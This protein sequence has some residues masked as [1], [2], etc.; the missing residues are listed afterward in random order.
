MWP[1]MNHIPTPHSLGSFNCYLVH[2]IGDLSQPLFDLLH[3]FTL[4]LKLNRTSKQNKIWNGRKNCAHEFLLCSCTHTKRKNK[5][6]KRHDSEH[7]LTRSFTLRYNS[8]SFNSATTSAAFIKHLMVKAYM[9]K[10]NLK[11]LL[12]HNAEFECFILFYFF[13]TKLLSQSLYFN[14]SFKKHSAR[15]GKVCWDFC[16]L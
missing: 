6:K 14:K 7:F 11:V 16:S 9:L 4:L 15:S 3:V 12:S 13:A 5:T 8:C 2:I 1:L 10:K